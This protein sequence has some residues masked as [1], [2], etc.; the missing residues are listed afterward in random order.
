MKARLSVLVLLGVAL[1]SGGVAVGGDAKAELKKFQGEWAVESAQLG[2]KPLPAAEAEKI[3]L[4]FTGGKVRRRY[5]DVEKEGRFKIDPGKKPPQIDL[6]VEDKSVEG[7]YAF[8]KGKL[9]LCVAEKGQG[10]PTKFESPAGSK[11]FL[12]VLRRVKK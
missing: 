9:T 4:T 2:G 5:G 12:A 7:V 6:T 11:T 8:K 1:A 10:R 3:T